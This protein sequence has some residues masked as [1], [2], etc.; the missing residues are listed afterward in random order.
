MFNLTRFIP[1]AARNSR[2]GARSF[3]VEA[4]ALRLT[5][6]AP[7]NA[8]VSNKE[9]TL[10]NVPGVSGEFGILAEHVPTIA[11][12]KPG[13]VTVFS[14]KGADEVQD[15][16]FI[17][18]GFAFMSADSSL[19]INVVEAVGLDLIDPE[20]AREGFKRFSAELSSASDDLS[21]AKAQIGV[22]VHQSLCAALNI[23]V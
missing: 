19:N 8:I 3:A 7:H 16:Y 12:L 1:R 18:G 22:E 10:V 13:V 11:E 6:A 4:K 23:T 20:A 21:R 9:V 2:I 14:K 5:L 17:S 15:K